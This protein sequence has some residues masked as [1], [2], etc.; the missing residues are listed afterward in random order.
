MPVSRR[1]VLA[2]SAVASAAMMAPPAMRQAAASIPSAGRQLPGAY[3]WSVGDFELT[4]VIDGI[5][6]RPLDAAFVR[7]ATLD[8]VQ[9]ALDEAFLPKDTLLNTFTALVVNTGKRVLLI[10]TGMGDAG[11]PTTGQLPE[12]LTAAG[13][14][15][16][17][18]DAVVISH[19]HG[20]HINGLRNKAGELNFPNAEVMVPA[21]EWAFW[22]D[23]GQMSRA[24]DSLK[25]GFLAARRVF[26]PMAK[27]VA[28]FEK[29]TEIAPGIAGIA[30]FGHTPGHTAFRIADGAEQMIVLSDTANHPALF[31]R[32]PDWRA[33]FDMDGDMAQATRH[34]MLDMV[35]ADRTSV[36][37]YH[38]PFPAGG[39]IATDG[40]AYRF[41]PLN[42]LPII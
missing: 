4:A 12:N 15:P 11:P 28:R 25:A 32:H 27:E 8:A 39:H 3:R 16:K 13:I 18:V 14:D 7:N 40:D 23:D 10:D 41:V 24:P 1:N 5:A 34:R 9:A 17:A 20:D 26:G 6:K 35:A 31:V 38:F 21:E 42:W 19:F 29:D 22:M 36:Q 2:G 30:A 33:V 37:G